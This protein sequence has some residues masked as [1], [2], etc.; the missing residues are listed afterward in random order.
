MAIPLAMVA[1][2][3]GPDQPQ[4][5]QIQQ[6]GSKPDPKAQ[7]DTEPNN[8]AARSRRRDQQEQLQSRGSSLLTDDVGSSS[9]G[10]S[11][12]QSMF[13]RR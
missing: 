4:R 9:G 11:R 1:Q 10:S 8:A 5:N 7:R 3:D 13:N 12:S 6:R 2:M